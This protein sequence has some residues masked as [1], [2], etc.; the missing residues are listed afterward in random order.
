MGRVLPKTFFWQLV[1]GT[2]LAQT[3]LLAA[4]ITQTVVS[5]S[6]IAEQRTR[7]RIVMQLNRLA[8]ACAKQLALGDMDSLHDVLELSRV[9]PTIE[10]ARL[11]DLTGKTLA[12]SDSGRNRGLDADE[13]DVLRAGAGQRVFTI[14]N[15]QLEAVTPV[16]QDGKAVALLW[17]EPNRA[18][19]LNTLNAVVQVSLTYGFFA[20]LAN[21]LPLF[22][23]TRTMTRPL[24][25][26]RQATQSVVR[27]PD[28]NGSFP[29]PVTTSNE[30]GELTTSFNV[31][32]QKL[33]QQRGGLLDTLSLLDSMLGN[34]PIG[35]AFFDR[36]QRC[37]RLNDSLAGMFA[38]S[39]DSW[40][41]KA[42]PDIY[43]PSLVDEVTA[44]ITRTFEAGEAIRNIELSGMVAHQMNV[45]RT[46]LV[47]FYP[48]YTQEHVVRSVGV[49]MVDTTERRQSEEVLR[50][51]EKLAATGRLAASI[52]HEINNPLEAV[53]NLLYLLD[54]H[55]P[56]DAAALSFV[57]SA[58]SELA[59]V[60]EITQQTLRFH[61]QSTLPD[62]ISVIDILASVIALYQ[63][64]LHA[65][66]VG[67]T[68]RFRGE[69]EIFGYGGELRQVLANLIGNAVDAMP[70]GGTLV[71]S[72]RRGGGR[73]LC[74]MWCE[75]VRVSVTDTGTGMSRAT[76]EKIFEAFFTTKPI[77]GTGLGLWVSQEII[78]KHGATVRVKSWQGP[79]SG[80]S[81]MLFFPDGGLEPIP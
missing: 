8:A 78:R 26:L 65:A 53:T 28:K 75:G 76:M 33:E 38:T 79:T 81:F 4:F 52:A 24:R 54:T 13:R 15:G 1:L 43:P 58:Q 77:T 66:H 39:A 45:E 23:I 3:L 68:K 40:L 50:K 7:Q 73:D 70:T 61:R 48:I 69:P 25:R 46:W 71:L 27:N 67:V 11:T 49:I 56:M 14:T 42:V 72:T 64:R 37:V 44:C 21:I 62:S 63:S 59:R 36:E 60:S 9:A 10:V 51:T 47:H 5:Q 31:M 6:H 41:G 2:F 30:A 57:R 55:E 29:L 20:L 32:V 74:G 16:V 34:A 19:S 17:L 18:L 12:V 35:F 22:L 80:T